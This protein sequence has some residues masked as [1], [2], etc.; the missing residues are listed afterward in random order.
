MH[1]S[2]NTVLVQCADFIK[3]HKNIFK[4]TPTCFDPKRSSSESMS[5]PC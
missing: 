4:G 1:V 2:I 3:I 5:V